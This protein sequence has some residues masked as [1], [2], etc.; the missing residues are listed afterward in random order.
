MEH[1]LL[2][3]QQASG[4]LLQSST[5]GAVSS[6]TQ[7]EQDIAA[8]QQG[9]NYGYATSPGAS[10]VPGAGS[11]LNNM[12]QD[13]LAKTQG[14]MV[15]SATTPGVQ[16][17]PQSG[18]TLD[19]LEADIQLKEQA[20]SGSG[21]ALLPGAV[22]ASAGI[23]LAA[24]E[25]DIAAKQGYGD[26]AAVPGAMAAGSLSQL[27]NDVLT[28]EMGMSTPVAVGQGRSSLSQM[29]QDVAAKQQGRSM[30]GPALVAG[31]TAAAAAAGGLPGLNQME[32]D[33]AAKTQGQPANGP[34]PSFDQL[35]RLQ[36]DITAKGISTS[37]PAY[38]AGQASSMNELES[39]ILNKGSVI[40]PSPQYHDPS[41]IAVGIPD[42]GRPEQPAPPEA[43][44]GETAP[45]IEEGE[46]IQAFV[47][48]PEVVDATGVEV[49]VSEEE[50]QEIERKTSRKV[51]IGGIIAVVIIVVII[52]VVAVTVGGGGDSSS[53]AIETA[54]PT[55]A[56]TVAPTLAPTSEGFSM[57]ASFLSSGI[58][59]GNA[60]E[61]RS[62]PQF[63][64]LDWLMEDPFVQENQLTF[65]DAAFIERYIL[66][67]LYFAVGG[68]FW[69]ACGQDDPQCSDSFQFGW[70]SALPACDW[71][72]ITCEDRVIVEIN[73]GACACSRF[74]K[75]VVLT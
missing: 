20:R 23:Q 26:R 51:I 67:V 13:V 66:G 58:S 10:A 38:Q 71:F 69:S 59:N 70:L 74:Q 11:A 60:F 41:N 68:E 42:G 32:A 55:Q 21:T 22:A 24:L 9:E 19:S 56:P 8:K 15:M 62:S 52:I 31:A 43:A 34:P 33:L 46:K 40:Q 7:M 35:D 47:A 30:A 36:D 37:R 73:L 18:R 61:D 14:G 2:V 64:S 45:D 28:K 4:V 12:E 27:E 5:P 50:E 39:D 63:R 48:D 16:S 75:S 6:L 49:I 44:P 3:K 65:S 17:I 1:D 53:A 54:A 57:A 29:E 72:S 25:S